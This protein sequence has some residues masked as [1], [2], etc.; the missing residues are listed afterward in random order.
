MENGFEADDLIGTLAKQAEK[1]GYQ[2]FNDSRQRFW[3]ISK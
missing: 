1:E 3:A 2:V